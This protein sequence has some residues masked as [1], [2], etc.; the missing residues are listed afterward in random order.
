MSQPTFVGS[1]PQ[2]YEQ[3]LVPLIF[4]PYAVDLAARTVAVQP[5]RV[6]EVAAG[7]GA[8][9]R[10]LAKALPPST[11]I[12]ATDLSEAMLDQAIGRGTVRHV[13]W[14][15]A[16]VMKLPFPDAE[17]D[18]VVCQFGV[19]FFPEKAQALAEAR[20]VLRPGGQL[21][22]SVWA[23]LEY[24]DFACTVVKAVDTLFPQNPL[25]FVKSVPHG[26]HDTAVIA[27]DLALAGFTRN[28]AVTIV[29]KVSSAASPHIPTV[30]FC[31]GTPMRTEL[32]ARGPG[33]LDAA[34]T[35]AT[36]AVTEQFGSGE[37]EGKLQAYVICAIR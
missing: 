31:W 10:E 12:V 1:I 22:F 16:D 19:M 35:V 20:R 18:T 4:Q 6:L 29:A 11:S 36:R 8:V 7:T 21:I 26:Y 33:T 34:T 15:L 2:L 14:Q 28:P 5:R 32:E 27:Q 3:Y 24:N 23:G 37:V 9:T 17:F 13:T 30:A 25:R